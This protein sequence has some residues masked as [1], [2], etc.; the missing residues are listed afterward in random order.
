MPNKKVYVIILNWNG[1][2]D[3]I[4]CLE[5]FRQVEHFNYQL[6]LVDNDSEPSN[7]SL[8]KQKLE[9]IFSMVLTYSEHEAVKGG[10]SETE[11]ILQN[12]ASNQ[13]I[14]IIKNDENLGFANGNNIALKYLISKKEPDSYSLLLNNDTVVE[15]SFLTNLI[16]FLAQNPNYVA[17][18]PQIRLYEPKDKIW[19][20]GGKITWFGN[21]R[22]FYAGEKVSKVPQKGFK[23][24]EFIT[25][26]AL[27]FNPDKTG[28]LSE[29]FFFGEEDF[30]FSL[31]LKRMKMK[32]ACVYD[33]VIYHKVGG[34]IQHSTKNKLLNKVFL[35]YASRLINH[36]SYYK[37]PILEI[38]KFINL[39]YAIF[40]VTFKYKFG[41]VKGFRLAIQVKNYI[42]VNNNIE[43][44]KF[45]KI[46]EMKF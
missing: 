18:T 30:E 45:L 33:S 32:M 17:C 42:K 26:C 5:S 28:I 29:K 44:W 34:T 11:S 6:I 40:L 16:N 31:R 36:K 8:L 15:P 23:N 4:E 43:K 24:I 19:N 38:L 20:C 14:L 39:T 1:T 27:L 41:L 9:A 25:G 2:E 13:S 22:Y 12:T 3:T 21:R 35:F 46:M 7:F 37:S 10:N